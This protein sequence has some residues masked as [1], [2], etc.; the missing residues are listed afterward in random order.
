MTRNGV[1]GAGNWIIDKVKLIDRWPGE[2]N[3]CNILSEEMAAGGGPC[4]VLFDLA[5]MDPAL[6]LYA[7]GRIGQDAAGDFLLDAIS[8]RHIDARYMRRVDSAPTAYT[9][10]MSGNGR[11][12]FFHCRGANAELS[13]EELETI[14][15]P[16]E[17]FYLGYLLLLDT[18]DA[19]DE[20]FGTRAAR[21]LNNM[22]ARGYRTVVDFVSEAPEKFRAAARAA[23]PYTDLLIINELEAGCCLDCEIRRPDGSLDCR[24]L[25]AAPE[26]LLN[27]GVSDLVVIHFPEGAVAAGRNEEFCYV[28]SCDIRREEIVGSNGTGDAFAAGVIYGRL[29]KLPLR[30]TLE[31]GSA[32]SYF[33]LLS[34]TASGGAVPLETMR[35][36]L[37]NCTFTPIPEAFL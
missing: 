6:E 15:V 34:S 7:A 29:R 32:S 8:A 17:Y 22:R 31:L 13:R 35:A 4:N 33:N 18:L 27:M 21:L 14:D 23:L 11:R 1:I 36:H 20:T 19:P 12:T 3:L 30:E 26:A 25:A 9:D 16:A 2:G 5:A 28:P 24:V 37:A 10:V